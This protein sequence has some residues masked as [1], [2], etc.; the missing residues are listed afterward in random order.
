MT[1]PLITFAEAE[2]IG[3][4]VH[5]RLVA[6]AVTPPM[7]RDDMGWADLAQF[8]SRQIGDTIAAREKGDEGQ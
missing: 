4:A 3:A 8:V 7:T 6:M 5:D 1:R 2:A